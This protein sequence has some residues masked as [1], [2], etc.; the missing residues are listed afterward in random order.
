[1]PMLTSTMV[2][3]PEVIHPGD[4]SSVVEMEMPMPMLTSTVVEGPE[5]VQPDDSSLTMN[6]SFNISNRDID[7]HEEIVE[8]YLITRKVVNLAPSLLT[9]STLRIS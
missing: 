9:I 1:M 6:L 3:G 2:E 8:R 5:V 7:D 4:T